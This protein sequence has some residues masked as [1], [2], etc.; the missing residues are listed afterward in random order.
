MSN[1][2]VYGGGALALRS[3][4]SVRTYSTASNHVDATSVIGYN[5]VEPP[6]DGQALTF[7]ASLNGMVWKVVGGGGSTGPAGPTG[8]QGV[9]VGPT[10]PTGPTGEA[11]LL[12]PTGPTGQI[13]LPGALGPIGPTGATGS[14]DTRIKAFG[15]FNANIAVSAT[16]PGVG[17]NVSYIQRNANPT[18]ETWVRSYTVYFTPG[19][20]DVANSTFILTIG[21][22]DF[23]QSSTTSGLVY[24][25]T[26]V[27][28]DQLTIYDAGVANAYAGITPPQ[29]S[30][31]ALQ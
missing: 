5:V 16:S 15:N 11:G 17:Y 3:K 30:V 21:V 31:M 20:V 26:I 2:W 19:A 23:T 4:G 13:G 25:P 18:P 27:V 12:G 9:V 7:N 1:S 29:L 8:A 10:G 22:T 24:D 14:G 28:A 6:A